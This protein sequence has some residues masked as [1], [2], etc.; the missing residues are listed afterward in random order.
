MT[1]TP[2]PFDI[3]TIA[4]ALALP[5]ARRSRHLSLV[6]DARQDENGGYATA[7]KRKTTNGAGGRF[8][9][10]TA[11]NAAPLVGSFANALY[12]HP[13]SPYRLYRDRALSDNVKDAS[14]RITIG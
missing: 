2:C 4:S 10:K 8:A 9:G 5:V 12:L 3:D 13:R 1:T 11:I 6:P 14:L 7:A